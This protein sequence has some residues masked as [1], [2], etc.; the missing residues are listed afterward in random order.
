[1]HIVTGGAGFIGS[2]FL[3][4]LNR[5]GVDKI[6]VVDDLGT[7]DKWKNLRHKSFV[8]YIHKDRFLDQLERGAFPAVKAIVHLGACSSTGERDVDYLYEN[9]VHYSMR[10]ARWAI[11]HGA[12]FIYASSAATYGAGEH[13]FDDSPSLLPQLT[14][15]N[16]YGFSKQLFDQWVTREELTTKI[17]GLRFFNVYGPNEFH[18]GEMRSV[19]LRAFEQ[20]RERGSIS[21]FKSYDK[22]YQDGE[23]LRDFVYV[24]D[25][26]EV[27]WWL[28]EN[29]QTHGI[30]NLGSGK[31]RTWNALAS[32]VAAALG[33][34]LK[35]DYIDMPE[36]L[37][38]Q[39]QYFTEASMQ[40]LMATR[41]PVKF[42]SLEEGVADY[43]QKHLITGSFC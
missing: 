10:L 33:Q 16:P 11:S 18:K 35:I 15:L 37:R 40:R 34:P 6:L 28:L 23:Q 26:A 39:Y 2:V 36:S 22:R 42:H 14:P 17:V 25:C 21:L 43:V 20:M 9:N 32:A 31:A 12:R 27:M 8:D 38:G 4:T 24:K 5:R 1:M 3:S 19:V 13:G 7:G 41:C 29:P 30:F